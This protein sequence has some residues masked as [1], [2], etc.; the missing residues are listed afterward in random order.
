MPR[1]FIG[2]KIPSEISEK[3][4]KFMNEKRIQKIP[5]IKT[6]EK[7]NL[8]ITLK[9]LG[10]VDQGKISEIIEELNSLTNTISNFKI[11]VKSIGIFPS[12]EHP[13]VIWI[14]AISKDIH[15]AKRKLDQALA[16]FNFQEEENFVSHITIGRIKKGNPSVK[17]KELMKEDI[18]FGEFTANEITLFESILT[19]SGPIYKKIREFKLKE[20]T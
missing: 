19:P 13:R 11:E 5:Y 17:I 12:I 20:K 8:H 16:K 9:F 6:V 10:E 15:D 14:G 1:I 2:I 3:I 7:E 4:N 18:S